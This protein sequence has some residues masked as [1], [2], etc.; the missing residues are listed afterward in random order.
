MRGSWEKSNNARSNY[1]FAEVSDL[2]VY[3][4]YGNNFTETTTAPSK[5]DEYLW[6]KL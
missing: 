1:P 4:W 2:N 6:S 3:K 5:S